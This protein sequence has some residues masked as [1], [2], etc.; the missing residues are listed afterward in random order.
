MIQHP[1][2]V[3][4]SSIFIY[5]FGQVRKHLAIQLINFQTDFSPNN[6]TV[7]DFLKIIQGAIV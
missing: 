7:S 5:L 2:Y 1:D 3:F 4:K 6:L